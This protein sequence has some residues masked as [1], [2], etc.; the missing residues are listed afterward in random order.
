[1]FKIN[2]ICIQNRSLSIIQ[3]QRVK[4]SPIKICT[5]SDQTFLIQEYLSI[6]VCSTSSFILSPRGGKKGG[7]RERRSQ[8]V[9]DS[10]RQFLGC[11]FILRKLSAGPQKFLQIKCHKNRKFRARSARMLAFKCIFSCIRREF[12]FLREEGGEELE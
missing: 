1:M 5:N 10:C 2:H 7:A 6:L 12:F 11:I 9:F 3:I 4:F 8:T